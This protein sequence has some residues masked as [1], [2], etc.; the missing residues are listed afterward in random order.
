M[1]VVDMKR[2]AGPILSLMLMTALL[3]GCAEKVV[4]KSL[5]DTPM[6]GW[7][8]SLATPE[9]TAA[10]ENN[11]ET[12][13][14]ELFQNDVESMADPKVVIYKSTHT[15]EVWDGNVMMARMRVALGRGEEGPKRK[16]G[17]NKTPEGDYYICKTSE[18]KKYYKSLF[19]S[20]PNNDDANEGVIQGIID[21][22]TCDVIADDIANRKQPPWDTDLGGEGAI[23]GEGTVG[24][25]KRG[26]WTA[27]NIVVSDKDMDY[28][29]KYIVMDTDV[30]INP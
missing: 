29:W 10:G 20:Y 2:H 12:P 11:G 22:E 19:L 18:S 1:P 16:T 27:G 15:L 9:N 8:S 30:E 26:D 3:A 23:C 21:Q 14:E 28:L 5:F 13:S 24:A 17:D 6:P 25:G 7:T 4:W